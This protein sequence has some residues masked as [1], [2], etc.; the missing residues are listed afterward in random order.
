MSE[1][2]KPTERTYWLAYSDG[3]RHSGIT[4]PNQVT[5]TGQA[6]L[7]H[8]VDAEQ[9]A[10]DV[11][12]AGVADFNP[13]PEVGEWVE[14]DGVYS[15]EGKTLVCYQ[16][17]YRT[18]FDPF[19]TPALFGTAKSSGDPWVQPL[20]AHDAYA[21]GAIVTHN[22]ATWESI[23]DANVWEPGTVGTGSLWTKVQ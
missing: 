14:K 16:S 22:G 10:A 8:D 7:I 1:I 13:L 18:H 11:D 4:E 5:T 2:N 17:H 21:I 6:S 19:D 15:H 9:F 23:V 3:V 20:G 12:N